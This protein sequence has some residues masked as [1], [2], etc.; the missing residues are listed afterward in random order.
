M[1]SSFR[2]RCRGCA[3]D[4]STPP[5]RYGRQASPIFADAL[6]GRLLAQAD[7][8]F[9]IALTMPRSPTGSTSGRC[10]R[11]IRNISADQRPMP[12][13]WVERVD[14]LVVAHRVERVERQRAAR[15]L[16]RTGRG[17]TPL[18]WR[19]MPAARS[20]S[21]VTRGERVGRHAA[22]HQRDEPAVD[23]RG[24][25]GRELLTGDRADERREM[26]RAL[27]AS[28]RPHEPVLPDDA[29]P[30]PGRGAS[31]ARLR[32]GVIPRESLDGVRVIQR[33]AGLHAA[34]HACTRFVAPCTIAPVLLTGRAT[35]IRRS[36]RMNGDTAWSRFR[37]G[38]HLGV[39]PGVHE[40]LLRDAGATTTTR[41]GCGCAAAGSSWRA[42]SS[43]T[44]TP[45]G[46][47]TRRRTRPSSSWSTSTGIERP[48]LAG[49]AATRCRCRSKY[50]PR[51]KETEIELRRR[52]AE[53][54]TST[55]LDGAVR[56]PQYTSAEM[57]AY[58]Y[59][60]GAARAAR[61]ASQRNVIIIPMQ[62]DAGV[63]GQEPRS[64]GRPISI[65]TPIADRRPR[66]RA[67]RAPPK[68]GISTI[69]R[70]LYYNPDGHGR[71]DEFDFITYFEC[72]DEHLAT[73]D[74]I[75]R[76]LRDERQNPE[77]RFVIEGP[78][79]RGKRVLR[80]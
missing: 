35:P 71:A 26:D 63:V 29:R 8:T 2:V 50:R 19:L 24:R 17:G 20:C 16:R 70:T 36:G 40:V 39:E 59:K 80:W 48:G 30:A 68:P 60:R 25:L 33:T 38:N 14:H 12:L 15:H 6:G 55:A 56:V 69:Y 64:I 31:A 66:R 41:R 18:F 45:K 13:T 78:E 47:A 22:R 52:V 72:A 62:Q 3:T 34:A 54:P 76:A 79:W 10:S 53:S 61:G 65:R 67:T 57:H 77:W 11:N 21:S 1:R 58:A 5:M 37:N 4:T 46:D 7:S 74:Q 32:P 28:R 27:G 51:L 23:R 42:G 9:W 75:C 73:F 49:R 44:S 43:T